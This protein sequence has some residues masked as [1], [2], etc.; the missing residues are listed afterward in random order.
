MTLVVPSCYFGPLELYAMILRADNVV[1][2]VGEHYVKQS[3]RTRTNI[4]GANGKQDLSVHI[5]RTHRKTP[6][7]D[8]RL[9]HTE[10]WR[11][12]HWQSIRSAYGQSAWFIHYE[13]EIQ[14]LVMKP[15]KMLVQRNIESMQLMMKLCGIHRRLEIS[16][17][18]IESNSILDLREALHPKLPLPP[19]V[20]TVGP[21]RQ[22]FEAK[23]GFIPRLSIL[24]LLMNMGPQTLSILQS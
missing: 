1:V 23:N 18:Y 7:K 19:V 14:D 10:N 16:E 5:V 22:V 2:D 6:M 24:D 3:Y 15:H 12:E 17:E 20:D 21:Y 8:M 4:H 11:A 13:Q 9:R